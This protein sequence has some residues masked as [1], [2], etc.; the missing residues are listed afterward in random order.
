MCDFCPTSTSKWRRGRIT[1]I[2]GELTYE[3]DCEGHQGHVH[4]DHLIPAPMSTALMSKQL[5]VANSPLAEASNQNGSLDTDV[6]SPPIIDNQ[7]AADLPTDPVSLPSSMPL[8]ASTR[9]SSC[10]RSKPQRLIEE[11]CFCWLLN[12]Y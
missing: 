7:L 5:A 9:K 2:C 6:L 3:V 8:P 12:L 11:L 10:V 4:I 1:A